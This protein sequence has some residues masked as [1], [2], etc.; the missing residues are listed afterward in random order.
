LCSRELS[1]SPAEEPLHLRATS[2]LQ[3]Q[4]VPAVSQA[5]LQELPVPLQVLLLS[6]VRHL[7]I[8]QLT[9]RRLF[10]GFAQHQGWLAEALSQL[11]CWLD[12]YQAVVQV[13]AVLAACLRPAVGLF[14][15]LRSTIN[16]AALQVY[17][18]STGARTLPAPVLPG[19]RLHPALK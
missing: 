2:T 6:A 3:Q 13:K 9:A 10:A 12:Q 5:L 15:L 7:L 1:E 17:S 18:F 16:Q 19:R 11:K 8:R 4:C 14:S